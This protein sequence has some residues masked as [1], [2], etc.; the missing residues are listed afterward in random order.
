MEHENGEDKNCYTF[1]RRPLQLVFCENYFDPKQAIAFEK[2]LKGWTRIKKEAIIASNWEKLKQLS[3]C[4]NLTSHLN[5]K[6]E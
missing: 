6:K 1:K 5:Y 3:A 4:K 2:Q